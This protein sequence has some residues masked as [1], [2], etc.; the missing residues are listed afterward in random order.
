MT[1]R[2]IGR[3]LVD[4]LELPSDVVLNLPRL[5]LLGD[6]QMSL[7]N[8]TGII[9][10]GAEAIRIGTNRGEIRIRG[11]SLTIKSIAREELLL[12]GKFTAV[13]FI[14]WEGS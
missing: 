6:G 11:S 5:T 7:V 4:L 2:S 10:Y 9:E 1:R 14:D 12:S 13:E 3:R 8:H